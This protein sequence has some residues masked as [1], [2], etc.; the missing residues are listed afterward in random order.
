MWIIIIIKT[1]IINIKAH[2]KRGKETLV[3]HYK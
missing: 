1:T 3:K 2:G